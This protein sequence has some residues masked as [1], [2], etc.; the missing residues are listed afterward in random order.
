M[1]LEYIKTIVSESVK[2][3]NFDFQETKQET[4]IAPKM[5]VT[6]GIM[7]DYLYDGSGLRIDGVT[8]GKTAFKHG[9][10]KGDIIVYIGEIKVENIMDYMK[11]LNE[12]EKGKKVMIKIIRDDKNINKTVVFK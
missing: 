3:K 5:N 7:P 2:I 9:L 4:T 11:G 1:I 6:L 10:K 8:K 12:I